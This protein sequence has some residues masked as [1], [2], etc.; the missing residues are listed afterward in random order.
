MPSLDIPDDEILAAIA[1]RNQTA[2]AYPTADQLARVAAPVRRPARNFR[3]AIESQLKRLM[4]KLGPPGRQ[5]IPKSKYIGPAVYIAFDSEYVTWHDGPAGARNEVLA[6]F[7]VVRCG[8]KT[9]RLK[10]VPP[11]PD[12]EHRPTMRAFIQKT[13]SRALRE[14][15]IAAIPDRVMIFSHFA[16]AD[17][18]AM[19]DF[20]AFKRQ[21]KGV[22]K[23]VVSQMQGHAV[24]LSDTYSDDDEKKWWDGEEEL[25]IRDIEGR[26]FMVRAIFRD[27][28]TLTPGR[29]GLG[30]A[31]ELVGMKKLNLHRDLGVPTEL[32][33]ER[34]G[35]E[36]RGLEPVYGIRRM[37]LVAR[38][39]PEQFDRY[40][41]QDAEIAMEVGMHAI[42]FACNEL[43]L[44]HL[45]TT[46][47]A[48]ALGFLVKKLG[49]REAVLAMTGRQSVKRARFNET[50]RRYV[51]KRTEERTAGAE[52]HFGLL[53]NSF[54][55]GD[56]Q[57]F[58][59]GPT[60]VGRYYDFDLPGAYTT[61]MVPLRQLD[62]E[63]AVQIKNAEEITVGDAAF[64]WIEFKYPR[65]TRFPGIPVRGPDGTLYFVL[66]GRKK[67]NVYACG[68]EIFVARSA[69][70]DVRIIQGMKVPWLGEFRPF[71]ETTSYLQQKRRDF[72]KSDYPAKN[73][74]Y[75]E[76]QSALNS[77]QGTAPKTFHFVRS[78]SAVFCAA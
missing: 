53:R 15:T 18:P 48:C 42:D 39:F 56:N 31:A 3:R 27:T 47:A 74:M 63:K 17:L 30:Y 64:A 29:K 57:C 1:R 69:G 23:T 35:C 5:R 46:L 13:L 60:P 28:I 41:F 58:Y 10:I 76:C 36:G 77:F 25:A 59:H 55:G 16:R 34:E 7:V 4:G 65:G 75:K 33:E 70:A 11:G 26:R 20:F 72:P 6:I 19:Q 73:A 68:P 40:G 14:G 38:D 52:I 9:T 2:A 32:A 22:G 8:D 37:D 45:P 24:D 51:T 21:F 61:A 12:R 66:E 43:G 50:A 44:K 62:Y 54:H 49:G 71:Q 67:D 78:V